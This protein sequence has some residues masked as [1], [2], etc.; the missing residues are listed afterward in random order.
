MGSSVPTLLG[1]LESGRFFC[2]DCGHHGNASLVP[3]NYRG[4]R[5]DLTLPWWEP[6][7]PAEAEAW[8]GE[9]QRSPLPVTL[10]VGKGLALVTDT[11]NPGWEEALVFPCRDKD[12]DQV[13]SVVLLPKLSDGQLLPPQDLPG[14][15]SVPLGWNTL[16]GDR[17]VFVDHPLIGWPWKRPAWTT[18]CACPHG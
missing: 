9:Q 2:A 1:H 6:L 3:S 11:D 14:T 8:L 15:Q 7:S 13:A 5:V 16:Q 4:S 18:W 10:E 12:S 17:I